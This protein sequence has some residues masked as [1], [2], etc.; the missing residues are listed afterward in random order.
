MQCTG[1][2]FV[3]VEADLHVRTLWIQNA[4]SEV[5]GAKYEIGCSQGT[6]GELQIH[7]SFSASEERDR[8][9]RQLGAQYIFCSEGWQNPVPQN[10]K[11]LLKL[12][13]RDSYIILK[14]DSRTGQALLK[15]IQEMQSRD[16]ELVPGRFKISDEA[17]EKIVNEILHT[18]YNLEG[19]KEKKER[20]R[21]LLQYKDMQ[22]LEKLATE[23]SQFKMVKYLQGCPGG[24]N[25]VK[26]LTDDVGEEIRKKFFQQQ[27]QIQMN[28]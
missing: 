7:Y 4:V 27:M 20:F 13:V 22:A 23:L 16:T 9:I 11:Y 6:T 14:C 26:Y 15:K 3:E 19:F 17:I 18:D 10:N 28:Q 8:A 25:V 24:T 12:K 5:P 1:T 2:R 21:L